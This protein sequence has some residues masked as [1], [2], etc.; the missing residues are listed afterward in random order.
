MIPTHTL[1]ALNKITDART[2][3]GVGWLNTDGSISL[4]LNP[5]INLQP[6]PNIV[7]TLFPKE[8]FKK[9]KEE[10]EVGKEV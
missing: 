7:L 8:Y 10:K 6:D 9:N 5:C 1:K 2:I 4:Q 3:C